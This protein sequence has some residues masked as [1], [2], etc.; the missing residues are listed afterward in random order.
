MNNSPALWDHLLK[1]VPKGSALMGGAVVDYL[2]GVPVND[3][4]IFYPYHPGQGFILPGD[5]KL[6]EAN[7]NDPVWIKEHE[8]AYLQGVDEFGNHPIATVYEYMVDGIHKVQ[9]I[10]VH[11]EKVV[12]HLKNFDHSLTLASY[13]K[14]GMF[15]HQKVFESYDNKI[16]KYV[17]KNHEAKAVMKSLA[18]AH[19]KAAKV[20]IDFDW[21]FEGF[22]PDPVPVKIAINGI[23][24]FDF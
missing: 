8:E 15:V 7:F 18:R 4:D 19:K 20:G 16:I 1:Y 24:G 11:Y 10:G 2:L 13:D 3:Y 23:G 6:T 22:D 9:L 12:T 17:S 5:W 14:K 21:Q